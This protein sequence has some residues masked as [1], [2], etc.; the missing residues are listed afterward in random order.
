MSVTS[1]LVGYTG[2][3]T[4]C[5]EAKEGSVATPVTNEIGDGKE[6]I[7]EEDGGNSVANRW[8]RQE[9]LALLKI[10]SDMDIAFR[11]SPLKGPLWEAISRKLAEVGYH[12][13]AKKCKEKFE[14]IYKYHRRTKEMRAAKHVGKAYRFS[15]QLEALDSQSSLPPLSSENLQLTMVTTVTAGTPTNPTGISPINTNPSPPHNINASDFVSNSSSSHTSLPEY[16]NRKK[17]KWSTILNKWIQKQEILFK[18]FLEDFKQLEHQR[19]VREEAWKA[20]E[21]QR[22]EREHAILV[23][24]RLA[25]ASHNATVVALLEKLTE[26]QNVSQLNAGS[27]AMI[28]KFSNRPPLDNGQNICQKSSSRW[29]KAEVQA[30]ITIRSNLEHKYQGNM[31]KG[32]LWEEVSAAMGKLGCHRS[33]KRCKE[34]WENINK[35]FKKV[36][37]SNKRRPEDCKTCPYFNQLE[38]LYTEKVNRINNSLDPSYGLNAEDLVMQ[39]TRQTKQDMQLLDQEQLGLSLA[40]EDFGSEDDFLFYEEADGDANGEDV[41]IGLGFDNEI[42]YDKGQNEGVVGLGNENEINNPSHLAIVEYV[43]RQDGSY[44]FQS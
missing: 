7:G 17:R 38:A 9:T 8:P 21:M 12:R 18:K 39:M 36:K 10:R 44:V 43:Q 29:P 31:P 23:Q 16:S 14:N 6:G 30:L 4:E 3:T 24:E 1:N 37:E 27:L 35:Y 11:E 19:I 28:G 13:S 25:A 26:Q 22:I 5:H 33:A 15:S 2:P 34:K 41:G 20:Q 42:R 32:Y 40:A